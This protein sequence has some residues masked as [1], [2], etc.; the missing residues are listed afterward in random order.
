MCSSLSSNADS[1]ETM[2]L[3]LV[4]ELELKLIFSLTSQY[5]DAIHKYGELVFAWTTE[6]LQK[7]RQDS[8]GTQKK[9]SVASMVRN[10]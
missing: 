10:E 1:G 4:L 3:T 6:L 8:L 2:Q 9:L 7:A 5:S